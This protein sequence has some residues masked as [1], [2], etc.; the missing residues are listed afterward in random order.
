MK[1][2]LAKDLTNRYARFYAESIEIREMFDYV[3]DPK[4]LMNQQRIIV[5]IKKRD[6]V[7]VI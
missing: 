6:K 7:K 5:N 3:E 1:F 2:K 4:S